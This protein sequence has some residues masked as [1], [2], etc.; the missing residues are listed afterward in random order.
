MKILVEFV[1]DSLSLALATYGM[2][3]LMT[4]AFSSFGPASRLWPIVPITFVIQLGL[5][6]CF[7]R[8]KSGRLRSVHRS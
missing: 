1:R 5:K 3:T 8:D 4:I 6:L 2:I 7:S